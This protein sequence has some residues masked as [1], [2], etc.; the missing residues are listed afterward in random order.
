MAMKNTLICFLFLVTNVL[1]A[2]IA[3]DICNS[4]TTLTPA[5][6]ACTPIAG[7][8]L[9][10]TTTTSTCGGYNDVYYKYVATSTSTKVTVVPSSDLDVKIEALNS[11]SGGV[12]ML[13]VNNAGTG[14]TESAIIAQPMS[15][16]LTFYIRISSV[17]DAPSPATFTICLE[18]Q[19]PPSNDECIGTTLTPALICTPTNGTLASATKSANTWCSY[20]NDVFYN[21]VATNT[22]TKI[23]VTPASGLDVVVGVSTYC[24]DP[25]I[26]CVNDGGA[27][28]TENILLSNLT[29]GST[30]YI[31]IGSIVANP[32]IGTFTVCIQNS[33]TNDDCSRALS[34]YKFSYCATSPGTLKNATTST[35]TTSSCTNYNDVFYKF[36]AGSNPISI[37]VAPEATLDA[38]VS[39]YGLCTGAAVSCAD[40]GLAGVAETLDLSTLTSG[41][42]YY[43]KVGSKTENPTGSTF[44]ICIKENA[45]PTNDDCSTPIGLSVYTDNYGSTTSG[46]LQYATTTTAIPGCPSY[47]EVFYLFKATTPNTKIKVTPAAG[48]NT[49]VGLYYS[50][51]STTPDV[52][53]DNGTAGVA[54][55]LYLNNLT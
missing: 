13:C 10:A 21:F 36:T 30:Y 11:C 47:K 16:G 33:P 46:S 6:A 51:T 39:I 24:S 52:C 29:V 53:F 40:N 32:T 4:A 18:R 28:V 49:V 5:N 43:I 15:I 20:N 7:T 26:Q 14:L 25:A 55:V 35:G 41:K 44:D 3:N 8:L 12:S 2:Q 50:C 42:E 17:N 9:N 31:K 48:L 34:L 23:I 22:H 27:G 1:Y 38:V 19:Y 54:D 37:T 45:P